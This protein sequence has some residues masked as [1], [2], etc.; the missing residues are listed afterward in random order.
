MQPGAM[1][2]K[3]SGARS[4]QVQIW[5]SEYNMKSSQTRKVLGGIGPLYLKRRE[6][7]RR[8]TKEEA[9][10]QAKK[11]KEEAVETSEV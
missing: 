9:Q 5:Q 6:Q 10:T 8:N 3:M 11:N 4:K 7:S 1:D 2:G